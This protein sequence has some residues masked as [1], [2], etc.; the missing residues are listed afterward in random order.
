MLRV[1]LKYSS[2][3]FLTFLFTSSI[4][5]PSIEHTSFWMNVHDL[6]RS[7]LVDFYHST[8]SVSKPWCFTRVWR[9]LLGCRPGLWAT[10]C[11]NSPRKMTI[12]L[13][14]KITRGRDSIAFLTSYYWFLNF[15]GLYASFKNITYIIIDISLISLIISLETETLFS[16]TKEVALDSYENRP[17]LPLLVLVCLFFPPNKGRFIRLFCVQYIFQTY[18]HFFLVTFLW[19]FIQVP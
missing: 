14:L 10:S 5:E 2:T 19:N 15:Y 16:L 12:N 11:S 8:F 3:V 9:D 6:R 13:I 4:L 1:A 17:G 18:S 7:T